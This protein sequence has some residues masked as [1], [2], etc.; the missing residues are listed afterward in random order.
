MAL[1]IVKPAAVIFCLNL[2]VFS[3][4]FD[5]KLESFISIENTWLAEATTGG[6]KELENK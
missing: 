3:L 2:V 4:I 6:G 1:P 5:T